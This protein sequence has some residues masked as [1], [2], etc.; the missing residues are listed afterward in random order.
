VSSYRTDRPADLSQVDQDAFGHRD[1]AEALAT[2]VLAVEAPFTIGLFG[3][4]GSGKTTILEEVERQLACRSGGDVAVVVFD[5]WRYEG[6]EAL[7]RQFLI[8]VSGQLQEKKKLNRRFSRKRLLSELHTERTEPAV[9]AASGWQPFLVALGQT[10]IAALVVWLAVWVAQEQLGLSSRTVERTYPVI[11]GAALVFLLT[12]LARTVRIEH[13][14]VRK[15]RLQDP[16]LFTMRFRRLIRGISAK[17]LVIAIDNLDRC[18]PLRVTEMLATIKTFLEPD[19]ARRDLVF[20]I[21][22]DDQALRRHL[23]AQEL[24]QTPSATD[25]QMAEDA[26]RRTVD[27]YLRKFFNASLRVGDA[28]D[29]EVHTYARRE[30]VGVFADENVAAEH[31]DDVVDMV[32]SALRHNP[33]RITQFANNLRLKL[34]LLRT[35]EQSGRISPPISGDVRLISKLLIIEEHWPDRYAELQQDHR[36]LGRWHDAAARPS[37]R[38]ASDDSGPAEADGDPGWESFLLSTSH[39]GDQAARAVLHLKL[40]R[41]EL[42]LPDYSSFIEALDTGTGKRAHSLWDGALSDAERQRYGEALRRH[43]RV[44]LR[45][46]RGEALNTVRV[47]TEVPDI[48]NLCPDVTRTVLSDA[49]RHPVLGHRLDQLDPRGLMA[50]ADVLPDGTFNR[51]VRQVVAAA[52]TG[53]EPA[54]Y[55]IPIAPYLAPRADRLDASASAT[56]RKAFG[57]PLGG[58]TKSFDKCVELFEAD[59]S[60][61]TDAVVDEAMERLDARDSAVEISSPDYRI[62]VLGISQTVGPLDGTARLLHRVL[63]DFPDRE[64]QASRDVLEDVGLW[65]PVAPLDPEQA[66]QMV[67]R[68]VDILPKV[69]AHLGWTLVRV[70]GSVVAHLDEARQGKAANLL[71]AA[72]VQKTPGAEQIERF[73][74]EASELPDFFRRHF[75][76]RLSAHLPTD[77]PVLSRRA[78]N[79][80]A[81]V[82]GA[83][84]RLGEIG[85]RA[86]QKRQLETLRLVL[87]SNALTKSD[88]SGVIDGILKRARPT[89]ATTTPSRLGSMRAVD[90]E[91]M[92]DDQRAAMVGRFTQEIRRGAKGSAALLQDLAADPAWR[93]II[94]QVVDGLATQVISHA[95]TRMSEVTHVI[96]A[97]T[98]HVELMAA[99]Q[100]GAVASAIAA[101]QG[102]APAHGALGQELLAAIGELSE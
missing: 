31:R 63:A 96:S 40:E 59:P 9:R 26:A 93:A 88:M 43:Y 38:T 6:E 34:D 91:R 76:D 84:K 21:A 39:I 95:P 25:P 11:L 42:D 92:S 79:A 62:A 53:A 50:I 77:D 86:A 61:L 72:Y 85:S 49:V 18:A 67:S 97:L 32:V 24:G 37:T 5:A 35:R 12:T 47:L 48:T 8:D 44:Q 101:G 29:E 98:P 99:D 23:V 70:G 13:V 27:E 89:S 66:Q 41:I 15:P 81:S 69:S 22:A 87:S 1:Y 65:L 100:R 102:R 28:L 2:T 78:I 7:R 36:L 64:Q 54:S 51:L 52:R 90:P 75:A 55:E 68:L 30:L 46:S 83:S 20:V 57:Q 16:E 10:A 3:E 56:L 74:Q 73:E 19:D 14:Q 33:R 60:L 71:I 58:A 94:E 45:R 17:R 4:W 82:P 80:I